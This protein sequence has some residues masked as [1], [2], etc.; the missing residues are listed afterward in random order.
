MSMR[1]FVFAVAICLMVTSAKAETITSS[2]LQSD[3]GTTLKSYSGIVHVTVSG[4][5]QS[6]G[7]NWNDAFYLF[8][9]NNIAY[10]SFYYQLTFSSSP[11][12]GYAPAQ[13]AVNFIVGIQPSYDPSHIYSFDLNT[14][15]VTPT[16]LHFGVSDGIFS[17]NSGAYTIEISAAVPEASTWGMMLLGFAS[18]GFLTYRRRNH[19]IAHRLA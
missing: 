14:G 17:D 2:F 11:L 19:T 9:G 1:T 3:G 7:T 18:V 8:D 6:Q 16:Q 12:V 4:I 13:D 10:D 15:A 5:G